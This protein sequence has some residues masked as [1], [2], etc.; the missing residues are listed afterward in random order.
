MKVSS[1]TRWAKWRGQSFGCAAASG[2]RPADG[3]QLPVE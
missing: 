3:G 2:P 1:S